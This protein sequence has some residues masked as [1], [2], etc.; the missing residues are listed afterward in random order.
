MFR[1]TVT[2]IAAV[3]AVAAVTLGVVLAPGR[4]R[5]TT[6]PQSVTPGGLIARVAVQL[7]HVKS[8]SGE[9]S[10]TNGLLGPSFVLPKRAPAELRQLW[11]EGTGRLWYQDGK[12]K[13][14]VGSP[15]DQV[16][17]VEDGRLVWVWSQARNTVWKYALPADR[18]DGRGWGGKAHGIAPSHGM[19]G[20]RPD[21]CKLPPGIGRKLGQLVSSVEMK[22]TDTTVAGRQAR[23]LTV[24]PATPNTTFGSFSVAFDA[25][26]SVPLRVRLSAAGRSAPVLSAG[27]TSVSYDSIAS[28]Q[29]SFTPPKDARVVEVRVRPQWRGGQ[30]LRKHSCVAVSRP[31]TL[32]QAR[33]RV[34]Y[35][36]ASPSRPVKALPF[37]NAWVLKVKGEEGRCRPPGVK[38]AVVVERYGSGFG[39]VLVVQGRVAAAQ[40]QRV[41]ETLS[42]V[43]LSSAVTLGVH[44]GVEVKTPLVNAFGWRSGEVVYVV[45]G[46]VPATELERFAGALR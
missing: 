26:T 37:Q 20:G 43:K 42:G 1:R 3:A 18:D 36:L 9:F 35:R 45:V 2:L 39:S 12:M 23:E 31:L 4:A 8:V 41:A 28:D 34:G 27:F 5:A 21:W 17:V 25:A 10:W 6:P 16:M 7:Q 24:M 19:G 13:L 15:P 33:N 11:A 22:V 14:L 40:L 29:F 44:R 32:K 46:M 38:G 30:R